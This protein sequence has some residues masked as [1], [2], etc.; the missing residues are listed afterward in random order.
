MQQYCLGNF[1]K[2][3]TKTFNMGKVLG[4][5]FLRTFKKIHVS[6][7]FFILIPEVIIF[8]QFDSIMLHN[9]SMYN[10]SLVKVNNQLLFIL[11]NYL[12]CFI[13]L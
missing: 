5:C 10:V 6:I 2:Q 4:K 1:K 3:Q 13:Y 12:L 8:S 9:L 11:L 7:L